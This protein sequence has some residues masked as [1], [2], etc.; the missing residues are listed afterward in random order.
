MDP[1]VDLDWLRAHRDEVVVADVRYYLD[2][3][4]GRAAYDSGHI[5]GAIFVDL[6][7]ALAATPSPQEGRHPFPT[8][9]L[10][11]AKLGALGVGDD[12]TVVAYDDTGG[13]MAARLVWMLRAIGAPAALLDGGVQAWDGP[14]ETQ[15]A[16]RQPQT[17]TAR[18]W[19]ADRLADIDEVARTS[20]PILDARAAPR[21]LG[22]EEPLDPRAGHIPGARNV[23]TADN[24]AANGRFLPPDDLRARFEQ[25]G[26]SAD[27]T[28]I[29]YCGSGVS[30]CHLLLSIEHAGLG[31]GRLYPGSWSQWSNDPERPAEKGA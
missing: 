27:E 5:P 2:G 15:A 26:L 20:A 6:H 16:A 31:A 24:L 9:D 11:A 13:I 18:P 17:R 1:I 30:A 22:E 8:P 29:A 19:P 14:L 10:F 4:P 21:F 12:D 28:P 3:R 7:D 23:S 25:A